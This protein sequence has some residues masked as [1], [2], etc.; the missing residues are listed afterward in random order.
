MIFKEH[1]LQMKHITRRIKMNVWNN[2]SKTTLFLIAKYW[3]GKVINLYIQQLIK[4]V[5]FQYCEHMK[6]INSQ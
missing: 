1:N 5:L 6:Q 3:P 4:N 2:N